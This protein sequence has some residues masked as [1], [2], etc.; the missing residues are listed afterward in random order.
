[1]DTIRARLVYV[2]EHDMDHGSGN[3][4]KQI[5][6]QF[7]TEH[8]T[9]I[10]FTTIAPHPAGWPVATQRFTP[11]ALPVGA[12]PESHPNG[13]PIPD[14]DGK[15]VVRGDEGKEYVLTLAP[16]EAAP[17]TPADQVRAAV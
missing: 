12:K 15:L 7:Q 13:V 3:V 16:A 8:G 10:R 6:Y 9:D 1:M 14:H 2:R 17:A 4:A 11:E 5:I